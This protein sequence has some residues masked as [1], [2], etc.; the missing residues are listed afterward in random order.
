VSELRSTYVTFTLLIKYSQLKRQAVLLLGEVQ[1]SFLLFTA[2]F[3]Q[4]HG[5]NDGEYLQLH[6]DDTF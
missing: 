1:L 6:S 3:R 2:R 5:E 4:V